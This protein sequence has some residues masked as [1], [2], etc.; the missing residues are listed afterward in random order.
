MLTHFLLTAL[1]AMLLFSYVRGAHTVF[2]GNHDGIK[3]TP[4]ELRLFIWMLS[5]AITAIW[6]YWNV[7]WFL[8]RITI[9]K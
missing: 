3:D 6:I 1:L 9:E 4:I 8:S 7:V 5:P 2:F